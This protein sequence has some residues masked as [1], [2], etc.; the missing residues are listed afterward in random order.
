MSTA[1]WSLLLFL[2]ALCWASAVEAQEDDVD[3]FRTD[4][5]ESGSGDCDP[6]PPTIQVLLTSGNHVYTDES[7]APAWFDVRLRSLQKWCENH[8]G[9]A[10][11]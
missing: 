4:T 5:G 7:G 9:A 2:S 11:Q 3:P 6:G 10:G 1:S 8:P